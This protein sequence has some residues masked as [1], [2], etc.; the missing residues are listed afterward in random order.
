MQQVGPAATLR[1]FADHAP[2]LIELLPRL[3]SA[4]LDVSARMQMLQRGVNRQQQELAALREQIRL[5]GRARRRRWLAIAVFVVIVVVSWQT[6]A[7]AATFGAAEDPHD[8]NA[9]ERVQWTSSTS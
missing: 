9:L 3:P 8:R 6:Q 4:L 1:E 5:D 2:E 7:A